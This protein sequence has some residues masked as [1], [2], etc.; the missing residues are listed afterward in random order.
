M[1]ELSPVTRAATTPA[2]PLPRRPEAPA[3]ESTSRPRQRDRADFSPSATLLS[4]LNALPDVRQGLVDRVKAEIAGGTYE[5]EARVD[6]LLD[7]L[8]EDLDIDLID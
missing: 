4:K 6:S 2:G 8:G 1:S 3:D 5:T 7:S